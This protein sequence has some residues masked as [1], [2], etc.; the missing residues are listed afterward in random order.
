MLLRTIAILIMMNLF[1]SSAYAGE[2]EL[3]SEQKKIT[4]AVVHCIETQGANASAEGHTNICA[5]REGTDIYMVFATNVKTFAM[6]RLEDAELGLMI[7]KIGTTPLIIYNPDPKKYTSWMGDNLPEQ[8]A[9]RVYT[10]DEM[11]QTLL[12]WKK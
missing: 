6:V 7:T 4:E 9:R 10:F 1:F 11:T 8:M 12:P 3:I 2:E 5:V